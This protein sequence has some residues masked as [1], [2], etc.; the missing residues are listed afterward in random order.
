MKL[1]IV[2][3]AG[4]L[5]GRLPVLRHRP[6]D[7][8]GVRRA[9]DHAV[10]FQVKQ[11]VADPLHRFLQ[12]PL[13]HAETD[14]GVAFP[15]ALCPDRKS[16][17]GGKVI[18]GFFLRFPVPPYGHRAVIG[19][20]LRQIA[21]PRHHFPQIHVRISRSLSGHFPGKQ[22]RPSVRPVL[23]PGA[24][25]RRIIDGVIIDPASVR[26][27]DGNPQQAVRPFAHLPKPF[28]QNGTVLSADPLRASFRQQQ[29]IRIRTE[30]VKQD[31]ILLQ[32]LGQKPVRFFQSRLHPRPEGIFHEGY[33]PQLKDHGKK[34][35]R[36]QR[37]DHQKHDQPHPQPPKSFHSP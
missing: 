24:F 16:H 25:L 1:P 5:T 9:E 28:L 10:L 15:F 3:H 8:G 30:R 20:L 31:R 32:L 26:H 33:H 6:P 11:G 22:L 34:N 18:Q 27:P 13:I 2:Q 14:Q 29:D 23:Q 37:Q 19:L 21:H 36:N 7:A 12:P 35:D 17:S 4:R